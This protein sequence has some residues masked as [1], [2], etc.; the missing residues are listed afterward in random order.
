MSDLESKGLY[1]L[2]WS[3]CLLLAII[4]FFRKKQ[5]KKNLSEYLRFL[6]EPWKAVTFL[7]AASGLTLVAPYTGDFT[8]DY[9]DGLFMSILTFT[10]APWAVG[11]IYRTLTSRASW[12]D[13]YIALCLML[14]TSSWSYDAYIWLRDGIYPDTWLSNLII[15]PNLYISGGLFWNLEHHPEKG[16]KFSFQRDAWYHESI[17]SSF[18]KL[19]WIALP[20][21]VLNVLWV[22]WFVV[23]EL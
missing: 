12:T 6:F 5:L 19:F 17:R 8:W 13:M 20:F 10:T 18:A 4:L 15:S 11:T 23:K 2:V 7:I 16:L 21:M 22:A 3:V 9:T 14:F 1:T